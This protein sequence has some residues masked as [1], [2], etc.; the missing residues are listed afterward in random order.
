MPPTLAVRPLKIEDAG[1]LSVLLQ[2]QSSSYMQYFTPFEFNETS[3]S[4]ILSQAEQ[5]V[6]MGLLWG[7]ELAGFFML[8]GWDAGYAVPAYGVTI[9]EAFRGA[10]LGRITLEMSKAIC[11]LR[12]AKQIMLK[13]HP[14]NS[15]AK[16]LYE[17]VGFVQTGIDPKN[18]NL[19]Y[20]YDF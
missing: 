13:V 8:R 3:I 11:R 6:Y 18:A 2:A 4:N 9:G 15:V 1:K 17:S 10:G 16:R 12:G 19:V 7:D 20:H 5:D 14:E